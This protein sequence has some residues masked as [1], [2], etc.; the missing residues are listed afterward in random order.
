LGFFTSFIK[1][2]YSPSLE[3]ENNSREGGFMEKEEKSEQGQKSDNKTDQPK[4]SDNVVLG[5]NIELSGFKELEPGEMIVLKKIVGH[6]A[7]KF[8]KMCE[9]FEK[10]H[11]LKKDVHKQGHSQKYEIHGKLLEDGKIHTVESTE[12]NLFVALDD[13]MKKLETIA[14]KD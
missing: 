8:S 13:V 14:K 11:I 6:F 12:H 9:N 7:E 5:G 4:P 3:V 1:Y 10:L 2:F